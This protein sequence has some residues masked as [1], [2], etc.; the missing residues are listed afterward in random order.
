MSQ[1][2]AIINA[3]RTLAYTSISGSYAAIGTAITLPLSMFRIVNTTDTDMFFSIDG[4]TDQLF[5]AASTFVLYDVAANR[6]LAQ[7]F[8]L[9]GHVQFYVKQ[10]SAPGRGAVYI[11]SISPNVTT[12]SLFA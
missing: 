4:S 2:Q 10:S 12:P 7:A 9:P 3:L 11:E 8:G 6:G 5:V 1:N